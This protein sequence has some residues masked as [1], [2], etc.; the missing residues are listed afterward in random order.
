VPFINSTTGAEETALSIAA[1]V[2]VDRS[3]ML[4]GAINRGEANLEAGREAARNA[5][6]FISWGF[7]GGKREMDTDESRGLEII[8]RSKGCGM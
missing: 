2:S 5:Y 3:R 4:I 6:S 8:L 7:R 1:L